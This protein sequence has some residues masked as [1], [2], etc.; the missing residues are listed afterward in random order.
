[1]T[2]KG[3]TRVDTGTFDNSQG[4]RL[5]S[6]NT[7]NLTAGQVTNQSAGRI[8]S[9]MALNASVTGL[10]QQAGEMFSN[11][12]LSLD[13]NHGQLNN[14]GGLINAPGALVLKNLNGVANQ[15]GEISSGQAFTLAAQNLDNSGGK[16]L[17]NQGLTLRVA[18]YSTTLKAR[19][20]PRV[21]TLPAPAWTT[22]RVCLAAA[23][24]ST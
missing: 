22:P 10:D 20:L 24:D 11:T 5:T 1:M 15:N 18:K 9:A 3:A 16:L 13:L 4:G 23:T 7:L 2:G 17:S 14:Q 19:F 21:W 6:S 12:A 8:A